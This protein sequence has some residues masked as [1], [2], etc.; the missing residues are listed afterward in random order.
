MQPHIIIS[1]D[2]PYT[3][4]QAEHFWS[5]VGIASPEECWW[6]HGPIRKE[7]GYGRCRMGAGRYFAHRV[8]FQL[9]Y[10]V[11]LIGEDISHGCDVL[12]PAGDISYR[13]CVNPYHLTSGNAKANN[14]H[15][16][17]VGRWSNGSR[18]GA[19]KGMIVVRRG[20]SGASK[21]TDDQVRSI[22]K[23][24]CEGT[25]KRTLAKQ[26]NVSPETIRRIGTRFIWG[27]LD[28]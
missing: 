10:G 2:L 23:Q 13:R 19:R 4:S 12:W 22:R 26:F 27:W 15:M 25:T 5:L 21:L 14:Q 3:L 9:W 6:W 11:T 17:E 16:V 24:I 18:N 7:N 1:T 8:A 20:V 28:D